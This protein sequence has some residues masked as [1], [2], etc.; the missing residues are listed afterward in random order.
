MS[1]PSGRLGQDH[2]SGPG[3]ALVLA[4]ALSLPVAATAAETPYPFEGTWTQPEHVCAPGATRVRTYTT[5]EVTSPRGRCSIRRIVAGSGLYELLEDCRHERN[6]TVTET[7]RM[8]SP[9]SLISKR[10]LVRL[11]IPR[12]LRYVRCTAAAP[13]APPPATPARPPGRARSTAHA[14]A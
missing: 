7:I 11:K 13:G 14:L 12:Q 5:K 9:D 6:P 1:R 10:Q 8:I 4:L 3:R 2:L